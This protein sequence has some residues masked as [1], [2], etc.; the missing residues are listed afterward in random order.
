VSDRVGHQDH[1]SLRD[2][3]RILRRRKWI[4]LPAVVLVPVLAVALSLRQQKMYRADAQV[5]LTNSVANQITGL[6]DPNAAQT[7]DRRA[8]TQADLARIQVVAQH[9]IRGANANLSIG[10]FLANSSVTPE[11]DAD[12]LRFSAEN[13][14]P[15]LAKRLATA[16][17]AAFSHYRA[18][19]DTSPYRNAL[20]ASDQQLRRMKAAGQA[21][22]SA[23]GALLT[24]RNKVNQQIALATRNARVVQ[25]AD[26]AVQ[27]SPRPRRNGAL[28]LAVGIVLGIGLAFLR[29]ALDT[30]VRSV[31]EIGER[32]KLTLLG[33]LPEP[34]RRLRRR[35][36]LVMSAEPHGPQS[37]AF[38]TLRTNI[39]FTRVGHDIR[40]I[41]VTSAVEKEGKSTTAANLA[42]A[43]A[44]GGQRVAL[45]DLDLRRPF[46]DNFFDVRERPGLTHV[47]LGA[48][49]LQEAETPIA[50]AGSAAI[51][52]PSANGSA[53]GTTNEETVYA[54]LET[55]VG[56]LTQN[57]G[58][59]PR[60]RSSGSLVVIPTG[61][62]PPNPGEFAAS[63]ALADLLANLRER[64]DTVLIDSPPALQ[65]G[66]A[67]ALSAYT[68]AL[69][70]VVRIDSVRRPV[71][72]EFHR[73]LASAPVHKLGFVITAA[74]SEEGYGS[75]G[76]YHA[77]PYEQLPERERIA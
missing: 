12:I 41:L 1:T 56:D 62:L 6:T 71:L 38:R 9:A 19:L 59:A 66:D 43:L 16:Y 4:I 68:D 11:S 40:T 65:V 10:A 73:T 21:G 54:R 39:E 48:A 25:P 3:F 45:V 17:A 36:E 7:P 22:T 23:Y 49:E 61:P 70:V 46:L 33:R 74:D 27:V 47:V 55:V 5:L 14:D 34:S 69:L 32:L 2:Y 50:F 31:E 60:L 8:Q 51:P 13:H 57:G 77:A 44:R 76:Y 35:N 20:Q 52:E 24:A 28:G 26:G 64:Y 63:A 29:E 75:G 58:F 53:H 30:R 37:E 18:Q 67:M 72:N 15:T 42:L